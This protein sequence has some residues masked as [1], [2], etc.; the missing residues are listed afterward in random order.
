MMEPEKGLVSSSLPTVASAQ[1]QQE[2]VDNAE[3]YVH[4]FPTGFKLASILAAV[5]VSYFLIFLDLAVMSTVTPA[6]TS[7]FDS[8]VDIGWYGS[9][10]Q[11]GSS[12]FQPLSGKIYR[13]FSIKAGTRS[14]ELWCICVG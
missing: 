14:A 1:D 3:D 11:L 13:Y 5:V 7:E 4:V 9:A 10:Y 2:D 8:L 12:A 6:I